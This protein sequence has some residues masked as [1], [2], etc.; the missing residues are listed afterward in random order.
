MYEQQRSSS[1]CIFVVCHDDAS[2]ARAKM[3]APEWFRPGSDDVSPP[4]PVLVEYVRVTATPYFE[5]AAFWHIAQRGWPPQAAYIGILPYNFPDK[6]AT[7]TH[8]L[9][10]LVQAHPDTDVWGLVSFNCGDLL[11]HAIRWHGE[12]F[13]Q[14]WHRLI[15]E[16]AGDAATVHACTVPLPPFFANAWVAKVAAFRD[17]VGFALR[18]MLHMHTHPA[19]PPLLYMDAH[20][21]GKLD[22]DALRNIFG[23]PHYCL[24]PFIMERMPCFYFSLTNR[25]VACIGHS[26]RPSEHC[27]NN[28]G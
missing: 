23:R 6:A 20:Y 7:Q 16:V 28:G 3:W 4:T 11:S 15:S 13:M 25:R 26:V 1:I 27:K 21:R 10:S 18:C 24:H 22:H 2:E 12:A 5:S 17:Y 14:A 9:S 8:H 19:M